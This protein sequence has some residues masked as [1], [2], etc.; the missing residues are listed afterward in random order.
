MFSKEDYD[1]LHSLVFRVD[2]TGFKPTVNEIPNG[3]GRE[4]KYKRYAHV[5]TK[6]FTTCA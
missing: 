5:A 6:Y 3:D 1:R 4:D 2:Y